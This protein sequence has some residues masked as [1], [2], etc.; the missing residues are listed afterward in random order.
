MP[1][2]ERG[3]VDAVVGSAPVVRSSYDPDV[4]LKLKSPISTT[5]CDGAWRRKDVTWEAKT[6]RSVV[7]RHK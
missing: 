4:A 5:G 3:P 7:A 2:D 6:K 1:C